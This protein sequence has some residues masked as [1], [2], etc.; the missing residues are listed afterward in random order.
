MRRKFTFW[1][2]YTISN[3]FISLSSSTP[4]LAGERVTITF[5]FSRALILSIAPP[6]PPEMI[7]PAWPI[8]L[9]GGA[10]SPAIKETTGFAFWPW[11]LIGHVFKKINNPLSRLDLIILLLTITTTTINSNWSDVNNLLNYMNTIICMS[12]LD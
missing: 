5:A 9:P 2:I 6:F 12:I 3:R 7:A 10:V 4:I 11:N 1:I 8:R